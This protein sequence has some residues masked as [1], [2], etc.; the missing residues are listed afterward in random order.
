LLEMPLEPSEPTVNS[1]IEPAATPEA[2]SEALTGWRFLS[3]EPWEPPAPEIE[4]TAKQN[5]GPKAEEESH[6]LHLVSWK[7]ASSEVDFDA[8]PKAVAGAQHLPTEPWEPVAPKIEFAAKPVADSIPADASLAPDQHR[9]P[10]EPTAEPDSASF[11]DPA[12][13]L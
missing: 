9:K 2:D 5:F 3:T 13:S 8:E 6:H 10:E 12:D 4:F 7:P 11:T 1:T